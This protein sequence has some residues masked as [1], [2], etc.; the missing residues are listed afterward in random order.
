[1]GSSDGDG[2][3]GSLRG[4][5]PAIT[6]RA[7]ARLRASNSVGLAVVGTWPPDGSAC[8]GLDDEDDADGGGTAVELDRSRKEAE[9]ARDDEA[10]VVGRAADRAS[11][12]RSERDMAGERCSYRAA[13]AGNG[14]KRG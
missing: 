4:C 8:V 7:L 14:E 3:V 12:D 6:P 10:L 5:L 13:G 9:E 2:S 1:M 11:E